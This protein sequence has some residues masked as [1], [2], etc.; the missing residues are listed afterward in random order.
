MEFGGGKRAKATD[1]GIPMVIMKP[2]SQPEDV[3][4]IKSVLDM[5]TLDFKEVV[6][7]MS[8]EQLKD[9]QKLVEET[10]STNTDQNLKV[11]I[12]NLDTYK[13]LQEIV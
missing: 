6:G 7:S 9:M 3:A 13:K 10:V 8:I 5:Q 2:T 12:E 11:F 1:D 4:V